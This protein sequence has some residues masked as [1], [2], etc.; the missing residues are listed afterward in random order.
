[1]HKW[2]PEW[3][4]DSVLHGPGQNE[5]KVHMTLFVLHL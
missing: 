1:M 4:T 3:N 5:Q 2:F